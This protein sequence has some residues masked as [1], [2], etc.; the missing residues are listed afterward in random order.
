MWVA[1]PFS[2]TNMEIE[3]RNASIGQVVNSKGKTVWIDPATS[4]W[5]YKLSQIHPSLK[6]EVNEDENV[7][8]IKAVEGNREYL[9]TTTLDLDD[10]FL[11]RVQEVVS[12]G[13]NFMAELEIVEKQAKRDFERK[14]DDITGDA[15]ER[16]AHAIR[17]ELGLNKDRAFI[18][19]N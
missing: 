6:L 17:K 1:R 9:V 14:Q 11:R 5:A 3:P 18:R 15:C 19:G 8:I 16:L 12:D 2:F 7:F 4:E 13:Y 10:R